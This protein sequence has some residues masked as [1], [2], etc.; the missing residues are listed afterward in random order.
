MISGLKSQRSSKDSFSG[1]IIGISGAVEAQIKGSFIV[2]LFLAINYGN[3]KALI[4]LECY[5][6]DLNFL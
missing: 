2:S 4:I 6:Y 1:V 3:M 5:I